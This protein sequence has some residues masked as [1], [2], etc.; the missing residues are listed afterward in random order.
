M[1]SADVNS[2]MI[3][4][5]PP[6]L[7]MKRRKTVSVTPAMGA[8]T[9]AGAMRTVPIV[10]DDGTGVM[11]DVARGPWPVFGSGLSQYLRIQLFYLPSK[12]KALVKARA[13]NPCPAARNSSK[14]LLLC[15]LH[16][17]IL[18]AETLD[19][20]G[21]V[22]QLLFAGKERVAS[23]ADFHVDIALVGGAG[24]KTATAGTHNA[25]FVI[26][27]MNRCLHGSPDLIRA[28]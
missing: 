26:S 2:V 16:F 1:P 10:T 12:N 3:S 11:V 5:H 14:N 13:R 6:R 17:G 4:P 18:P 27:G 15:A 28:I 9:V 8:S 25:H 22:Q 21:R 20:A 23:R 7:R 24:R 19:A